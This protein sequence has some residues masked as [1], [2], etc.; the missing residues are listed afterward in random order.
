MS[1]RKLYIKN[2]VCPRCIKVVKEEL[3]KLGLSVDYITLG[4]VHTSG[5]ADL[6]LIKNTLLENGFE[7]LDDKQKQTVEKIKVLI[8]DRIHHSKE[9]LT[10]G[11]N[12]SGYLSEKMNLSYQYISTLF[13]SVEETTIE[14]FIINQKIE[15]VKEYLVYDELNL[16]EISY[17][18]GYSSLQHLSNQFKRI[19][20]FSPSQFKKLKDKR[21]NP[22]G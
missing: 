6:N 16:N 7:L 19:T 15:K 18:L 21:R 11:F 22:I 1:A 5:E 17:R 14:K 3:E 9:D 13:S 4:E 8:I 2:M 20:G 12:F 10:P